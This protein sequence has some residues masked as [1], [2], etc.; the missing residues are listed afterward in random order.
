MFEPTKGLLKVKKTKERLIKPYGKIKNHW[1]K[2]SELDFIE[3]CH[4]LGEIR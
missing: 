4:I 2:A 1:F 3:K